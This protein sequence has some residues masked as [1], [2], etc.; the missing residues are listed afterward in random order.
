MIAVG[1]L[2]ASAI[3]GRI[4]SLL[5]VVLPDPEHGEAVIT[6]W[7]GRLNLLLA[8]FN[9]APVFSLDDGRILRALRWEWSGSCQRAN[10]TAILAGQ[11]EAYVCILVGI[12]TYF[13]GDSL[14]GVWLVVCLSGCLRQAELGASQKVPLRQQLAGI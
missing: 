8:A 5:S 10:R 12:G 3:P 6:A 14:V 4:F 13:A 1:G 11:G 7:L 9:L 2:G